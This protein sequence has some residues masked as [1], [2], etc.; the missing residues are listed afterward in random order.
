LTEEI[1][2][3]TGYLKPIPP[4]PAL[5]KMDKKSS[6]YRYKL[7]RLSCIMC[8]NIATQMMCYDVNGAIVIERYC[9]DCVSKVNTG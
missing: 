8:Y 2:K 3:K 1:I 6:A 4:D 5:D 9:D 7:R